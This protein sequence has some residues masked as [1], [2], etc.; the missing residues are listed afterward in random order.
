M[1][2]SSTLSLDT[3]I[4]H[5]YQ[6]LGELGYSTDAR[7]HFRGTW[8]RVKAFADKQGETRFS[9]ELGCA[10]LESCGIPLTGTPEGTQSSWHR[11]IRM[12]VRVLEEFSVHGSWRRRRAVLDSVPFP[13]TLR[14]LPEVM[15]DHW[16]TTR[17]ASPTTLY[18]MRRKLLEWSV[19]A[20]D[21][22]LEHWRDLTRSLVT[23]YFTSVLHF[24]PRTVQH[25]RSVLRQFLQFGW[26]EGVF[27]TDLSQVVPAV[28][29]PI[30]RRLPTVWS[31]AEVK[32]VLAAVDQGSPLGKRDYAILLLVAHL[33]LRA[34]EIRQLRLDDFQWETAVI[35]VWQ[36][37]TQKQV[38]LPLSAEVG[39]AV[40]AYLQSG[41]PP[42]SHREIFLRH[43]APFGPFA[44]NDNLH[45][46][47]VKYRR[48]AGIPAPQFSPEGIHSLRHT[49]ATRMLS[50]GTRLETIAA[51]LG[52][53]SVDTTR[54]YT[55]V[56]LD[57]LRAAALDPERVSHV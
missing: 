10:F 53:A 33:G 48:L 51:I 16:K 54:L 39:Q 43:N 27:S 37:K 49:L 3:L 34:G 15:L 26:R 9:H 6:R 29:L 8:R 38:I 40:I 25:Y 5:A 13:K 57:A 55:R 23:S 19:Y 20:A 11:H 36:P 1:A 47:V 32:A 21:H 52:H 7:Q 31:E 2:D 30:E 24:S 35:H 46:L 18:R 50:Q 42:T 17:G 56:D 22:G 28:R 14:D 44:A 12:A 41:R 45:S 4:D